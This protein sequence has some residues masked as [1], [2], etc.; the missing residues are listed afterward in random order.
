M[1]DIGEKVVYIG[2]YINNSVIK[3]PEINEIVTIDGFV[4]SPNGV[5]HAFIKEFPF[6]IY[7]NQQAIELINLKKIDYNF[8]EAILQQ[9]S[10]EV[11]LENL[12]NQENLV[13]A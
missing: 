13:N 6:D 8:A 9:I 1:F 3:E 2:G 12:K 11:R 7:G 5:I 4:P 10:N